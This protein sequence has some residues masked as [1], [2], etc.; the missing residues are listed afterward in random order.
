MRSERARQA[1]IRN[2]MSSTVDFMDQA[3][4]DLNRRLAVLADPLLPSPYISPQSGVSLAKSKSKWGSH[5]IISTSTWHPCEKE[6][7]A[8]AD[9]ADFTLTS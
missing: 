5:A 9:N 8:K 3:A 4:G 6:Y 1:A 7:I 2:P